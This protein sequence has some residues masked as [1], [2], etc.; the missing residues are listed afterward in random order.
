[1]ASHPQA[2]ALLAGNAKV[3][4]ADFT[5]KNADR[6]ASLY[7]EPDPDSMIKQA[8]LD[9]LKNLR[10]WRTRRKLVA[11]AVDDYCN[12]RVASTE[13]R[14]RLVAAGL[15][16]SSPFDRFDAVETRQELEA[17]FEVLAGVCDANGRHA[18][19]TAYA[20]TANPDFARIRAAR[21]GYEY[22]SVPATFARLAAEQ[23]AAYAGAW[24]LWKEGQARGLIQP[25]FHGREHLNVELFEH[26]LRSGAHDLQVNLENG[27]MAG[28]SKDQ[29]LPEVSFTQA[30]A[31]HDRQRLVR[32]AEIIR[33]GLDM[34]EQAWGFRSVS[35]TPPAQVLSPT[36]YPSC[37]Q[38][39]IRM[40]NKTRT[41]RLREG[42]QLLPSEVN[43]TGLRGQHAHYALVRNAVF[44]P[45]ANDQ[46][47][48][49]ERALAQIRAAFRWNRPAVVSS[50]RV[51]YCGHLD[52]NHRKLGLAG[53]RELLKRLSQEWPDVEYIGIDEIFARIAG[54]D[55]D[56]GMLAGAA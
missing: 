7:L 32:H 28:L 43:W 2:L 26:K 47:A 35:F 40:I 46:R 49:V 10:G 9:D 36:L 50:H 17:L 51:N 27:C 11:F 4:A 13:A 8:L 29:A 23:P 54:E 44:E 45:G 22:E 55:N 25:Q 38:A 39:G 31:F 56:Q 20:V 33:D 18:V 53:L 37:E 21:T 52:E 34:F 15:D 41:T 14:N 16:M 5:R 1:M 6:F 3:A 30:F 12:V 42:G 48:S 19:F 24:A